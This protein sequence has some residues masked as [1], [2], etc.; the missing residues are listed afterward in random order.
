[1]RIVRV[2][3]VRYF[4]VKSPASSY[5][6]L[7]LLM[8][9]LAGRHPSTSLTLVLYTFLWLVGWH[10]IVYILIIWNLYRNPYDNRGMHL[11]IHHLIPACGAISLP[12]GLKTIKCNLTPVNIFRDN[13]PKCT[14]KCPI[15]LQ[16]NVVNGPYGGL[17][18][19]FRLWTHVISPNVTLFL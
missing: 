4:Y 6:K 9:E 13:W 7:R 17:F 16:L 1:M 8:Y 15:S 10:V 5:I 18:V 12:D 19:S 11:V 14:Q 2:H 3:E